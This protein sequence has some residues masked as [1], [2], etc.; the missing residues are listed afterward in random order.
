V[1][2]DGHWLISTRDPSLCGRCS[3]PKVE[4]IHTSAGPFRF[5]HLHWA[6]WLVGSAQAE[7]NFA[8]RGVARPLTPE[9]D[10]AFGLIDNIGKRMRKAAEHLRAFDES[11]PKIQSDR[12]SIKAHRDEDERAFAKERGFPEDWRNR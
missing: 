2:G 8:R 10:K 7:L 4:E 1:S 9:L 12:A 3:E 6:T 5:C 11:D